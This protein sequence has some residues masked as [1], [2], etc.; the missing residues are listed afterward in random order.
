MLICRSRARH[1]GQEVIDGILMYCISQ[2]QGRLLP[3]TCE[4]AAGMTGNVL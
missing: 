1:D 3:P 2:A 4:A